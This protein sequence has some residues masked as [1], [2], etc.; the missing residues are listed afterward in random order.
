MKFNF[1]QKLILSIF[2]LS[3][4]QY[5]ASDIILNQLAYSVFDIDPQGNF[6]LSASEEV[7]FIT[8]KNYA[9]LMPVKYYSYIV[10]FI[11]GIV[12]LFFLRKKVKE[13]NWLFISIVMFFLSYGLDFYSNFQQVRLSMAIFLDGV[14]TFSDGSIN[15]FFIEM[16]QSTTFSVMSGISFLSKLTLVFLYVFRPVTKNPIEEKVE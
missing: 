1:L 9:L 15:A 2:L 14:N 10:S 3:F 12:S 11:L 6:A 13:R 7:S 4:M 16:Y 5:F 8:I